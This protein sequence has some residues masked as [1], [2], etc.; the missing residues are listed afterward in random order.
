MVFGEPDL[1]R[2]TES[3]SDTSTNASIYAAEISAEI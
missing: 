2:K 3:D 1:L